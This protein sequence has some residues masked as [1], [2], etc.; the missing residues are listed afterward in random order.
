[1][2]AY[3]AADGSIRVVAGSDD[4]LIY[5]HTGSGKRYAAFNTGDEVRVQAVTGKGN[6][7]KLWAGSF[8]GY[9]YQFDAAGK[10]L[11]Y[12]A[13]PGEVTTL[14]ALPDGS[15]LA[16]TSTG[17]VVQIDPAGKVVKNLQ[18]GGRVSSI[19][20]LGN[21]FG[22]TTQNGEAAIYQL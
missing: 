19:T 4:G 10:L 22:V 5:F 13:I 12:T 18:L 14:Q 7:Q 3:R 8:N 1:M 20:L 2:K 21:T 16:G 11:T 17:A 6:A 9:V 15:V